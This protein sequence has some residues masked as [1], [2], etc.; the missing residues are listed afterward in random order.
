MVLSG[1]V[2]TGKTLIYSAM[3]NSLIRNGKSAA[4]TTA[5]RMMRKIKSTWGHD[6]TV[7]EQDVLDKYINLDLL[8][9]DEIGVQFNKDTEKTVFI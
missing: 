2:G 3:V 5:I 7:T 6:S 1:S 4:I 8:I 9:I